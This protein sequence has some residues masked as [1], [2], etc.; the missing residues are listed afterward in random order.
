MVLYVT[1]TRVK[2]CATGM[3]QRVTV[4]LGSYRPFR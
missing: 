4:T 1:V 2:P 3:P